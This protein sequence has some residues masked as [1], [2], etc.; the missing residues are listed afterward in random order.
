[1]KVNFRTKKLQKVCNNEK[2]CIKK[3][4]PK[5]AEKIRARLDEL[6]DSP[7]LDTM[8]L[9]PQARFHPLTG[10]MKGLY[11]VDVEHP[12]RLI[13]KSDHNPIPQKSDGGIDL[14]QVTRVLVVDIIDYH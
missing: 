6:L 4:G 14:K 10:D 1:M 3:F 13:I 11:A 12:K 7:N 8:R 2:R 5:C 9:I